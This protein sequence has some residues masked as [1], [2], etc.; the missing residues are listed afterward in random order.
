MHALMRRGAAGALLQPLPHGGRLGPL[1][2]LVRV[3][4]RPVRSALPCCRRCRCWGHT[5]GTGSRALLLLRAW[6]WRAVALVALLLG[7][8]S[9][10]RLLLLQQSA[11]PL[12]HP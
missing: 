9:R 7:A 3:A 1:H 5:I 6:C 8:T 2:G 11:L 12:Q 10:R 4:S